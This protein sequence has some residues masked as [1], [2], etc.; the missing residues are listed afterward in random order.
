MFAGAAVA[1]FVFGFAGD[2]TAELPIS[3]PGQPPQTYSN[4]FPKRVDFQYELA[5]AQ[6]T[7]MGDGKINS[8]QIEIPWK[9]A[10]RNLK[11][12]TCVL[13]YT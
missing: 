2:P 4:S 10:D 12:Y 3:Y 9:H 8:I 7:K 11:L 6:G 5:A 13:Y 1:R